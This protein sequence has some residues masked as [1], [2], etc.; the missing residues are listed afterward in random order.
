MTI[1]KNCNNDHEKGIIFP[2]LD[3]PADK[4]LPSGFEMRAMFFGCKCDPK[5]LLNGELLSRLAGDCIK[6]ADLQLVNGCHY[7][8]DGGGTTVALVLA[9]SHLALHTWPEFNQMI[10][11]DVSVCN[12]RRDNRARVNSL[13]KNLEEI[14]KPECTFLEPQDM[15][16][17]LNEVRQPGSGIYTEVKK[18]YRA[19]RSKY[20]EIKVVETEAFG[21]ALILDDLMQT[22]EKDEY[23]Y[24][25]SLVHIPLLTHA[26]PK[27]VLIC[28]GGDGGA[29]EE[30]LKHPSVK[31]CTL[32]EL[33]EEV[34]NVSK[35]YLGC[36][37]NGV[38]DNP[39]LEVVCEDAFSF[40]ARNQTKYDV[41]VL[42]LTD[43]VGEC[44]KLFTADFYKMVSGRMTP[45]GK[46]VVH[47]SF[48]ISWPKISRM[49]VKSLESNFS[50][51]RP[52]AQFIPAYCDLMAFAMCSK[53]KHD[54]LSA[55][56]IAKRI[57]ERKIKDLHIVTPET[58]Q[59]MF[60]LPPALKSILWG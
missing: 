41:I 17:R 14:F 51:I 56:E 39:K 35:E 8:F 46:L 55:E 6:R 30:V 10:L 49:I 43:P 24:H 60:V 40:I 31:K 28:G 32:V 50:D 11:A 20:Q 54:R 57:D 23:W 53:N 7:D 9:E 13:I 38:F 4:P 58:Y 27:N 26:E 42:D 59:S 52:Y 12:F 37:N 22:T 5:L 36:V 19:F 1:Q 16:P 34:V 15:L 47:L 25:E 3:K 44:E 45:D 33:D 29:A 18:I 2:G 48:P 21:R